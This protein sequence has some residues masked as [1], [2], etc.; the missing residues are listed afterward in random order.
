MGVTQFPILLL[1]VVLPTP[2]S[3]VPA[4]AAPA[5][6]VQQA[7][8]LLNL[9][10]RSLNRIV[11]DSFHANGGP[12]VEGG[13]AR[14]SSSVGDLRYRASLS[15]PVL[16][17]GR[18]RSATLSLDVLDARLRIGSLQRRIGGT[19]ARCEG[20]GVDVDP[21]RPLRVDLALD[22]AV[23]DRALRIHPREVAIPEIEERLQL[24]APTRCSHRVLPAWFLWWLGKPFLRRSIDHLD[25]VL[26]ERARKGAARL[27]GKEGKDGL[28]R[29]GWDPEL[30]L[31]PSALETRGGSLLLG[32]TA[33]DGD[34]VGVP[35]LPGGSLPT[36]SFLGIS[37]TLVNE[38]SRRLLSRKAPFRSRSGGSGKRILA[39]EAVYALVPG[40]RTVGPREQLDF[41]IAFEEAPRFAFRTESGRAVIGV[42]VSGMELRIRRTGTAGA[43]VLGT[44]RIDRGHMAAVPTTNLL[45]G[46][47]FEVVENRWETSSSGIAFDDAMVAATLQEIAFGRIFET[48]YAPLF[49]RGLRLGET[50]FLPRSFAAMDGYLVIGLEEAGATRTGSL[51]GSR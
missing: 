36:E 4:P 43:A 50:A 20:V 13:R 30:H 8:V 11:V 10:E 32:L 34:G 45:G 44:L 21:G 7:A 17:L 19:P 1:S 40:L 51:R 5:V 12:E 41:E 35:A 47:S 26:L 31:F 18:D 49:A 48:S 25:E 3:P 46:I 33:S 22:L 15:D 29:Q 14:V 9:S 23:E 37:E 6:F 24:V 27:E 39:S 2:A 28:V 42:T 16:K 38:I